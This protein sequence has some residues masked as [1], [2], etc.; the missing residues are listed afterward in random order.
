MA[1]ITPRTN[2]DGSVSY[3]I[4]VF[5]GRDSEGRQRVFQTTWKP[6]TAKSDSK[7]QKDLNKLS[8]SDLKAMIDVSK[9]SAGTHL[10][11]ITVVTDEHTTAQVMGKAKVTVKK[12]KN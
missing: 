3:R 8:A 11:D 5:G 7:N 6:D 12:A 4:R 2:K 1:T 10:C 9:L